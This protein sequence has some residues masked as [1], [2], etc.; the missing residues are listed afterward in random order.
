MSYTKRPWKAIHNGRFFEINAPWD[1]E[2]EARINSPS[3]AYVWNVGENTEEANAH[4]IAAAPDL[5]EAL[6]NALA[7]VN[8]MEIIL[9]EARELGLTL[10][11]C[12][13]SWPELK[14]AAEAAIAKAEG[15]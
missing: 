2:K 13:D 14:V 9:N 15:K 8:D 11:V 3:V 7:R 6:R 12:G 10:F 1:G 5:L 4:L